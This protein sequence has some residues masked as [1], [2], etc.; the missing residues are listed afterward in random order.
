[1]LELLQLL[2]KLL[3]L[4][5]ILCGLIVAKLRPSQAAA[6]NIYPAARQGCKGRLEALAR[7]PEG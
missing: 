4:L 7:L 2:S 3:S 5:Q 1:M 6:G